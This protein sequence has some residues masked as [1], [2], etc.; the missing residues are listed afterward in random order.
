M[1]VLN[2]I[3]ADEMVHAMQINKLEDNDDA[4]ELVLIL[5]GPL[6]KRK[7]WFRCMYSTQLLFSNKKKKQIAEMVLIDARATEESL[8]RSEGQDVKN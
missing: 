6:S 2:F 1:S 5:T 4:V 8:I 3:F 7:I